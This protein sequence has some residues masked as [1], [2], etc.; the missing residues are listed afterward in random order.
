M[1]NLRI[2]GLFLLFSS[3]VV[4]FSQINGLNAFKQISNALTTSQDTSKPKQNNASQSNLAVTDEGAPA[5]KSSNENK[6]II[7][8]P[9]DKAK[10]NLTEKSTQNNNSGNSSSNLAVTDEGVGATKSQG[11]SNAKT[12]SGNSE[13]PPKQGNSGT[14]NPK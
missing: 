1:K 13:E 10:K 6:K 3:S 5:N 11:K 9:I 4:C 14:I 7:E 2:A 8:N 12:S